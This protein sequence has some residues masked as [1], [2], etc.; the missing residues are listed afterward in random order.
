MTNE[1]L[2]KYAMM[3]YRK[4]QKLQQLE[5]NL[6]MLL[7]TRD[8]RQRRADQLRRLKEWEDEL[9]K[10]TKGKPP[11]KVENNVDLDEPPE[12]FTYVNQCKVMLER[13]CLC[14]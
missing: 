6:M 8:F 13:C 11:L 5:R 2:N 9:N 3:V 10:V 1:E 12:G 14:R 4:K 7:L